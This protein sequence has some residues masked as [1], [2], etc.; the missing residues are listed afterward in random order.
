MDSFL[1]LRILRIS[2]LHANFVVV[3]IREICWEKVICQGE[4]KLILLS[5]REETDEFYR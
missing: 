3:L 4:I 1:I 2:M 5:R